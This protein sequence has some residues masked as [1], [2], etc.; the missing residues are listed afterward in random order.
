MG[1]GTSKSTAGFRVCHIAAGSPGDAVGLEVFFDYIV[2]VNGIV[3]QS[4]E[5]SFSDLIKVW[6]DIKRKR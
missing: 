3:I 2:E 6:I 1:N 4:R 5:Q